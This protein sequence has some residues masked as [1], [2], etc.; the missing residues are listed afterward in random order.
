[1]F[2]GEPCDSNG[3]P[4]DPE[5]PPPVAKPK[6]MTDWTPYGSCVAFKLA[7]FIYR[8]NQMSA[9][10]FNMLCKLWGATLLPHDDTLPF[11]NHS[12]LCQTINETPVRGVAWETISLSYSG[13]QPDDAPL[14]MESTH[15]IW[16][17][18]PRLL[19]KG[20]LENPEFQDFF[21][22]APLRQ[23]DAHGGHQYENVMS[24][25]WAWKQAVSNSEFCCS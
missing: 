24:G 6:D 10:D 17:R 9:G 22:Y 21:D 11:S 7:D 23:Y 20:M 16:F 19:F 15:K 25:N 4:L 13:P 14:W 18:D 12:E 3:G 5:S 2:V 8:R 1:V